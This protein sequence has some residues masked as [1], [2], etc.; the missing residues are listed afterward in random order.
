M[1]RAILYA[2]VILSLGAAPAL[3]E[4]GWIATLGGGFVLAEDADV[5]SSTN[6]ASI[7]F[8]AGAGVFAAI[9]YDYDPVRA[10][11]EF[12]YRSFD[13]DLISESGSAGEVNQSTS[14][15]VDNAGLF[16]NG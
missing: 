8:D 6:P 3:A 9:G 15:D 10:E 1:F 13:V 12:S 16:I 5:E 14:G 7:E 4:K 2:G 11:I